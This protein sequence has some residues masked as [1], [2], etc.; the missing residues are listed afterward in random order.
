MS[1]FD[2]KEPSVAVKSTKKIS[3]RRGPQLANTYSDLNCAQLSL[4]EYSVFLFSFTRQH[5]SCQYW[6]LELIGGVLVKEYGS[7][8][9]RGVRPLCS[10]IVVKDA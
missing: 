8:T 7:T 2:S 9:P 10:T 6:R 1:M 5:I 4:L 3:L